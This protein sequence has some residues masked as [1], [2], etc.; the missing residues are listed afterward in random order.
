M[1]VTID[2]L[3]TYN[4]INGFKPTHTIDKDLLYEFVGMM[5]CDDKDVEIIRDIINDLTEQPFSCIDLF[6][7]FNTALDE[8]NKLYNPCPI[9]EDYQVLSDAFDYELPYFIT[10][11]K[12]DKFAL[13][14]NRLRVS[15]NKYKE[16][17]KSKK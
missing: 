12:N 2:I 8:L 3:K 6:N 15:Y 5:F 14:Q 11:D 16:N 17:R 1:E 10:I 4:S 9:R 13:Y 7:D